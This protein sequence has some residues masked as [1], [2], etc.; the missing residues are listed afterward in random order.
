MAEQ[1]EK[2]VEEEPVA[3]DEPAHKKTKLAEDDVVGT[4]TDKKVDSATEENKHKNGNAASKSVDLKDKIIRQV[5]YYFGDSNLFR[6]AFL[7]EEI[8]KNEGWVPLTTLLTFK[9]LAALS[10]DTAVIVAALEESDS[11]LLEISD[12]KQSIRRHPAN[13]L[14]EKNE[15]TRKEIISRTAY[16]KGFPLDTNMSALIE[17]FEAFPKVVN[18]VMRKYF[19]KPTKIHKFKG[20]VFVTF[21][22]RDQCTDYLNKDTKFEGA[23]LIK[24]WQTDYYAAKKSEKVEK[25]KEKHAKSEPQIELPKGAVLSLEGIEPNTTRESIKEAFASQGEE[26]AFVDFAKGDKSG[27]IR[28]NSEDGARRVSEKLDFKIKIDNADVELN[29][30]VGTE[31]QL[32]LQKCVEKMKLR[33]KNF[34]GH[35]NKRSRK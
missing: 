13:P 25:Q 1:V 23:D 2:K 4:A 14:P 22:T 15:V 33:R 21:E 19:D 8:G 30:L 34:H 20:S 17:Y 10:T 5:E 29:M 24:K 32:Y 11:G 9:R 31:E 12:D 35:G 28:F 3:T 26:I 6:D 7:Q 16:V 18:I 27:W